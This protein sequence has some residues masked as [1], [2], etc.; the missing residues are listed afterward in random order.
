MASDADRF[1]DHYLHH[2]R[3]QRAQNELARQG[4]DLLLVGPSSDL[5]YLTGYDAHLSERL[6]LLVLPR[7]GD[8]AF[9][10]PTL[11]APRLGDRR[12]LL[13]VHPW[14]ETQSPAAIVAQ[15]AGDV[16]GK[17]IAVGDQL[18]S[19]FLLRLQEAMPGARW[20]S[21]NVVMRPLRMVKDARE[22]ELLAEAA[23]R[24]DDA[25][26]EFISRPLSGQTEVQAI[27]RLRDLTH[28]RGLEPSFGACGS[29]PNSASPHHQTG[30]RVIQPG[31]AVVF[32]WGGT[33]EGYHSDVTRTVHVGEPDGEFVRVYRIVRD[34]N[35]AALDAV[36]PG[37]PCEDID[38]AARNLIEAEGYGAA[39]IH[40]VGHGLG[41]DVHEEPYLISGNATPL[42]A[43]MVFSDEPGI[44]LEGRFGVRIEDAVLCTDEG[45]ERLN[46]ATRELTIV[47]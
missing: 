11:E 46:N 44:Y 12:E 34:A 8:P 10:L 16:A 26:E 3:L 33:L 25:W 42:L 29:G 39:F 5:R 4:V 31:D 32:D 2:D 6:N 15:V 13:D 43:G 45:G 47:A 37:V 7:E 41:L 22:I 19:V 1:R 24:T 14:E 21:G 36:R 18:W 28:A 30:D 38:L 35:Q 17:T 27:T 40:R 9:V 23:R 20:V